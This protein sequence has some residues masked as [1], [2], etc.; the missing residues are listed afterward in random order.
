MTL[1][2]MYSYS[3]TDFISSSSVLIQIFLDVC[4]HRAVCNSRLPLELGLSIHLK[5]FLVNGNPLRIPPQSVI[6]KGTPAVHA[7]K[8]KGF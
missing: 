3:I 1:P 8:R 6:S 7:C 2:S 5:A 4:T